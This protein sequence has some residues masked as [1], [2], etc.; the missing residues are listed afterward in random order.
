M[1]EQGLLILKSEQ[2]WD[3]YAYLCR[4]G[5]QPISEIRKLTPQQVFY[6]TEALSR[7]VKSESLKNQKGP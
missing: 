5:K 4:F 2:V 7:L 1:E 3:M 6:F